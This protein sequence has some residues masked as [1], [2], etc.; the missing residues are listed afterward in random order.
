VNNRTDQQLLRDYV[1]NRSEAAFNELARRHVDAV[2]SAALRLTRDESLAKD[3]AQGSFL[4]LAQ[5]AA[6][7]TA[8]PVLSGW[9]HCTTRN[10]AANAIRG[11][12]RRRAREQEAAA[13]NELLANESNAAW[14]HIAPYLD[15]ALGELSEADRDA[16]MLRYF[17]RKSAQEMAQVLG[18]SDAA[19]QKRVSR[20]VERLREFLAKRGV[21]VGASGLVVVISA[22]AVQAA[23]VGLVLTIST[24]AALGGTTIAA[25][26][27]ATATKAIAMTVTQKVLIAAALFAAV[28]I[29]AL[30]TMS[31]T[32]VF[33][34]SGQNIPG[35]RLR[36]PV[37]TGTPAVALGSKHGL[38]LASDGSLWSWGENENGW[39]VL[40]LGSITNQTSLRRIGDEND[41]RSIAVS[42]HHT[43]AIKSDGTMWS[44]GENGS[45]Q[46]GFA[47][48]ARR[49]QES[50]PVPAAA[51]NDWKQVAAGGSHSL[52][53]RSNGTLWAWGNGWAGQLG[54]GRM[55]RGVPGPEQVGAGTNWAKAW[56]G[57]LES[58]AIQTD[59]RLWYWGGNPDPAISLSGADAQNILTPI[60]IGAE[61]N[62]L[63]V[64]FG[65]WTVLA[66]RADG[67]LWCW[68]RE[69]HKFTGL[70]DQAMNATP[71]R[72]GSDS[73]WRAICPSGWLFH[74]LQK[75]DGSLWELSAEAVAPI[76][77]P[78]VARLE[79]NKDAVAFAGRGRTS[80]PHGVVLTRTGEVWTWGKVLGEWTRGQ[81]VE[82]EPLLR[83]KPWLLSREP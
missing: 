82:P 46:L 56:A 80:R 47:G 54:V 63:D 10:L 53:I 79:V 44:W 72:V 62:W 24:A 36:L 25:I 65:P 31:A 29:G 51:G 16:L 74:I 70:A 20:A 1:V 42:D 4:A 33:Q 78:R 59:G 15:A 21:T 8:H 83:E 19:A 3:I 2:Y 23:P 52:G 67:T 73:N 22:N 35:S 38:I 9:L 43:L 58:V 37:G 50:A 14:E 7:L 61:T 13:M 27:T 75:K 68:G 55:E 45:G 57:G 18:V 49:P 32:G 17:E 66:I 40:G 77:P 60:R 71:H 11:E 28:G 30:F 81:G 39:S 48:R 26:T 12:A 76:A 5:N 64:G 34:P 69:A 41:W 6:A